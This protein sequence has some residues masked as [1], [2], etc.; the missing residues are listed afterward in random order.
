MTF[1]TITI[2]AIALLISVGAASA[3]SVEKSATINAKPADV[4]AKIGSFCAISTWHPAITK[5]ALKTVD[6]RT[7]RV[8]TLGDGATILEMQTNHRGAD[9]K[10]TNYSYIIHKSPL[11]I[12]NYASFIGVEADGEGSKITWRSMFD[13]NGVDDA[14]AKE[15]IGGIYDGGIASIQAMFKK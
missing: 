8:L 13:A 3:A 2:T 12:K 7:H 11:P 14:K 9:D 1:K 15:I 10:T 6:H 4:W 5:C